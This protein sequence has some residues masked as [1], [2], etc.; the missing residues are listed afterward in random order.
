MRSVVPVLFVLMFAGAP[1]AHGQ[2]DLDAELEA[3]VARGL[4]GSEP[5]GW[6]LLEA[7]ARAVPSADEEDRSCATDP[8]GEVLS[9]RVV[10]GWRSGAV[11]GRRVFVRRSA[12]QGS[13]RYIETVV[14]IAGPD[15]PRG[16]CFI[17]SDKGWRAAHRAAYGRRRLLHDVDGDGDVELELWSSL[18][19]MEAPLGYIPRWLELGEEEIEPVAAAATRPRYQALARR[20]GAV[21]A[22]RPVERGIR[23][24]LEV[25]G[26]STGAR[27]PPESSARRPPAE[28]PPR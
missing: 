3:R 13:G 12:A 20:F 6:A 24:H 15:G 8:V 11:A 23:R 19:P 7:S 2:E 5:V 25:S 14:L 1:L 27:G 21:R 17:T 26:T 9:G 18:G 4:A 16:R 10:R 28:L 22:L